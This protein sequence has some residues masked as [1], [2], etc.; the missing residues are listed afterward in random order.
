MAKGYA[1]DPTG[2]ASPE[3]DVNWDWAFGAGNIC[4]TGSGR[5]LLERRSP[6]RSS[7]VSPASLTVMETA[8]RLDDGT[9]HHLQHRPLRR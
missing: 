1:V 3:R 7:I 9:P 6:G 8:V 2:K 4:A 5:P